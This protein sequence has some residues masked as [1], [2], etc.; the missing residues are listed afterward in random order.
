[1]VLEHNLCTHIFTMLRLNLNCDI[2]SV[3]NSAKERK[4]GVTSRFNS[5]GDKNNSGC[6][7][8]FFVWVFY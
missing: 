8:V 7:Y 1:M 6:L 4:A 3:F 5:I 2:W